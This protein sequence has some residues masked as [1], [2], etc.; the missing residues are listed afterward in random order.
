MNGIR[1]SKV[2]LPYSPERI[3]IIGS[4]K[5]LIGFDFN[6]LRDRSYIITVNDSGK[7]VPFADA[8]FTLD[9]WGLDSGQIPYPFHGVK[10]AAVPDDF[11]TKN[12]KSKE[13]RID[14]PNDINYLHRLISHNLTSVTSETALVSGLSEDTSCI[15][16]GNSGFGALGLAYHL[17]PKKILLLGIDAGMG[18]FYTDKKCNR[19]LKFLPSLFES[20]LPQLQK[21]NISVINGSENSA[22]ECFPKYSINEALRLFYD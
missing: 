8:W 14:A 11:G 15:N 7:S 21:H 22:I 17:K 1:F 9:P 10:Y 3:I 5:S 13:H 16:T 6:Q 4:G 20:A 19:P 2:E 18:Y 12:A